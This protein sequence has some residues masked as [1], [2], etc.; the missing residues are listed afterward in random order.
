MGVT[1]AMVRELASMVRRSMGV[2]CPP[3]SHVRRSSS[4]KASAVPTDSVSGMR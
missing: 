4:R 2:A 1:S 3:S